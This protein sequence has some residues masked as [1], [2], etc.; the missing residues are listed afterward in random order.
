[1]MVRI[2]AEE[3]VSAAL[4]DDEVGATVF[5]KDPMVETGVVSNIGAELG[6]LFL[7]GAI[8]LLRLHGTQAATRLSGVF[9]PPSAAGRT[10]SATV[11][12]SPQ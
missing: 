6:E 8:A 11:A 4:R 5:L 3:L 9:V 12:G 7:K 10:W 2:V 1:M